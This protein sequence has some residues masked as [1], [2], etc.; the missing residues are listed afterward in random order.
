MFTHLVEVPGLSV[1]PLSDLYPQVGRVVGVGAADEDE[2]L[3]LIPE[4]VGLDGVVADIFVLRHRHVHFV[5]DTEGTGDITCL[6]FISQEYQ[7]R[8]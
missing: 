4:T 7:I 3:A 6:Y 1:Q 2:L 5:A 8:G